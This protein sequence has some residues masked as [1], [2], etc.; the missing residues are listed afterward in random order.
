MELFLCELREAHD[1]SCLGAE[2]AVQHCCCLILT[3]MDTD[4]RLAHAIYFHDSII[5]LMDLVAIQSTKEADAV[6]EE[7]I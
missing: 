6:I 7:D 1:I 4:H 5:K 2:E 3:Y